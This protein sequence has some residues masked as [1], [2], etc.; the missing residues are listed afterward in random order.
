MIRLPGRP[1]HGSL[2]K[3]FRELRALASLDLADTNITGN[4]DVLK[5]NT[6][7]TYLT[8]DNTRI[9]GDLKSL[10][11]NHGVGAP[12]AVTDT[13]LRD[14]V[15]LSNAKNL[16]CL[17]LSGTKVY[18]DLVALSN[19]KGLLQLNLSETKVYG[20]LASFANLTEL[21]TLQL[22]NTK[23]S[24][25]FSVILQ[26]K[27][28]Q[29]LAFR[30]PKSAVIQRKTSKIAAKISGLW[31]WHG[32]NVRI[33]DG[34]LEDFDPINESTDEWIC[35]FRP[36]GRSTSQESHWTLL[37]RNCSNPSLDAQSCDPLELQLAAWRGICHLFANCLWTKPCSCWIYFLSSNN[38]T[39]VAYIPRNARHAMFRENPSI[40]FAE[41]VVKV[42]TQDF[43]TLDL[44]NATFADPRDTEQHYLFLWFEHCLLCLFELG[45]FT[46][47]VL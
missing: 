35:P 11:K 44:R 16:A 38:V 28:I 20:D 27:N 37:W 21:T 10:S 36:W 13:G 2:A 12:A 19:A 45:N 4:L 42:A 23:V 33:M 14:V 24:C 3:E 32:R 31:S 26:W 22:S 40:G 29:H 9:S 18:G 25:D 46:D 41:D 30:A 43:V 8:L 39:K 34:F 7:L 17:Y 5:E 6:A 47:R 1:L 15:A